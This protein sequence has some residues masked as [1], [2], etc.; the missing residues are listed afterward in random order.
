M[1]SPTYPGIGITDRQRTT[2]ERDGYIVLRGVF[3]TEEIET[4]RT[5]AVAAEQAWE[6]T[7]DHVGYD[8]PYLRRIEPL[9]EFGDPFVELIDHPGFFPVVRELLGNS[10]AILDTALFITPPDQGWGDTSEWHID[11]G[12]TGPVGAPIPLMVKATIPLDPIASIDDGPTAVIPGSHLRSYEENQVSPDDPRDMPNS[13]PVLV[14]PGDVY[15]F[16]GRVHHAAMPNVGPRTRRV[17]HYN[18]SH[19]WMKP[20]PGHQPS[21][22]L[23]TAARGPLRRQLLHVADNHYQDRVSSDDR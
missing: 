18:Y 1:S 13:V 16:H 10:I 17:L 9:I 4:L 22:R 11:E 15:I 3:S 6:E 2:F 23:Q 12:L 21:P 20:W 14:D 19:I 5:A 7:P 8:R